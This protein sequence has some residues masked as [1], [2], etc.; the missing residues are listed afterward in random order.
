MMLIHLLIDALER[1]WC[2]AL[3]HRD[4]IREVDHGRMFLRCACGW[5][6]PGWKVR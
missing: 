4:A 3:G 5:I 1:G 2:A 6:S